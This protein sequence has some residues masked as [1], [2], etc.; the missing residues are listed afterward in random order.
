MNTYLPYSPYQ[1]YLPQFG[2]IPF[3]QGWLPA[4]AGVIGA[5]VPN[6]IPPAYFHPF[7][8]GIAPFP[9]QQV[10]FQQV[11][12]QQVPFQ[13]VPFQQVPFQQVPFQQVP[14]QG[15]FPTPFP[16][17]FPPYFQSNFQV[18]F[19]LTGYRPTPWINSFVPFSG[20]M[21]PPFN[22]G[23]IPVPGSPYSI[24]GWQQPGMTNSVR[25]P[26]MSEMGL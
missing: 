14:F 9:F 18:P 25:T 2:Q 12:F 13:Q 26:V 16:V 11:P 10:T 1:T 17:P 4:P 6:S 22:L 19:G 8:S 21:V 20:T 23:T 5:G 7:A 3:P 24:P 15:A